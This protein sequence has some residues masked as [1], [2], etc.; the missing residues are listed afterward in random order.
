MPCELRRPSESVSSITSGLLR[1]LA[2]SSGRTCVGKALRLTTRAFLFGRTRVRAEESG[3]LDL[4]TLCNSDPVET[5]GPPFTCLRATTRWGTSP[6]EPLL[7]PF[8]FRTSSLSL[9]FAC[10]MTWVNVPPNSSELESPTRLD[11]VDVNLFIERV[12][13][14]CD[15]LTEGAASEG[16]FSLLSIPSA[17]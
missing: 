7:A 2:A 17:P 4:R 9:L 5:R 13:R 6:C 16:P 11:F 10:L 14:V 1:L 12:E 3:S 15:V 8:S